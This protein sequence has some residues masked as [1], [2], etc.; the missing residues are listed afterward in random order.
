LRISVV[1]VISSVSVAGSRPLS[2]KRASHLLDE[3]RRRSSWRAETLT[4]MPRDIPSV[5]GGACRQASSS[6]QRP[7]GT[8]SPLSSAI[9]MNSIGWDPPRAGW[10]QRN[11]RL[12]A[13]HDLLALEVEDR[14]VEQEEL[15]ALE[16][17]GE[18]HLEVMRSFA[19]GLHADSN[20][21]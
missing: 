2:S 7:I 17:V 10:R 13:D 5:P 21:A 15:V 6:T 8:I 1:S 11:Q 14:L 3:L 4:D 18:V 12:D 9:G 20:S 19:R 16:R